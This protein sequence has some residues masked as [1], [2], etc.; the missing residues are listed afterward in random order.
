M[1]LIGDWNAPILRSRLSTGFSLCSGLLLMAC[2][3]APLAQANVIYL[4]TGDDFTSTFG[5]NIGKRITGSLTVA[6]PLPSSMSPTSFFLLSFSFTDGIH[7]MNETNT[8]DY[9]LGVG[10]DP[11]G[12]IINWYM[13]AYNSTNG[14]Y[15]DSDPRTIQVWQNYK[16]NSAGIAPYNGTWR[17]QQPSEVPEPSFYG[18]ITLGLAGITYA[19]RKRKGQGKPL[20]SQDLH[21]NN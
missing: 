17:I 20:P 18:V 12:N 13:E 8:R 11:L 14:M 5:T 2:L 21:A 1:K 4:Y 9:S 15:I 3:F 7:E 6:T 10:T 16:D 19:A